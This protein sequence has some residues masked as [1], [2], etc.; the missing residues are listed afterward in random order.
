VVDQEAAVARGVVV[1]VVG[2]DVIPA[3]AI[4]LPS[5]ADR[6]FPSQLLSR[7]PKLGDKKKAE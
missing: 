3:P 5:I 6:A 2:A 1:A 4:S 7:A